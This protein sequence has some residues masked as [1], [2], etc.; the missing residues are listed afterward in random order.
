LGRHIEHTEVYVYCLT[1]EDLQ[2]LYRR[3]LH[4]VP[5]AIAESTGYGTILSMDREGE[6]FVGGLWVCHQDGLQYGYDF[7]PKHMQL[8]RDRRI[9]RDFDVQWLTSQMWLQGPVDI[10]AALV[11]EDAPDVRYLEKHVGSDKSVADEVAERFVTTYGDT[12]VPVHDH[13]SQTLAKMQGYAHAVV[14]PK[15]V[16][17]IIGKSSWTPPTRTVTADTPRA[18]LTEFYLKYKDDMTWSMEKAFEVLLDRSKG[19][20]SE[21]KS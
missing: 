3:N 8:D 14:V 12:A 16:Y 15:T 13:A 6:L 20:K 7:S 1:E 17:N 10:A 9:L 11:T 18:T 19:W 2:E 5:A 4:V 21:S